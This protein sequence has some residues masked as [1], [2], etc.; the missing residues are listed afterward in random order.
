[1]AELNEQKEVK[2]ASKPKK[3][4]K[5]G[6]FKRFFKYLREC[7]S[8]MKKVTWLSRKETMK[9]SLVVIVVTAA[10]CAV[11]GILDT[12]L[13]MGLIVGLRLALQELVNYI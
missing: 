1:M 2:P 9:S 5:P 4:K 7:R 13:E 3:Q 10:L 8:E 11:I 6:I 12:A